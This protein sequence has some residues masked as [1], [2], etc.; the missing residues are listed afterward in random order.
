MKKIQITQTL[1]DHADKSVATYFST[2]SKIGKITAEE[3]AEL[4]RQIHLGDRKALDK[5][6]S[7]NLRFVVTEL[8]LAGERLE[9]TCNHPHKGCLALAVTAD[10]GDFLSPLDLYVCAAE[11]H[12]LRISHLKL[13]ALEHHITVAGRR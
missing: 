2:I 4:A 10:K 7:A 13:T 8:H 11:N 12:L 6:V 5:L 3:E 1:T 9:F